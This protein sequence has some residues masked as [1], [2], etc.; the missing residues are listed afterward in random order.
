LRS[1]SESC[2]ALPETSF[3]QRKMRDLRGHAASRIRVANPYVSYCDV[4]DDTARSLI[5]GPDHQG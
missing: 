4:Y 1:P 5:D 2:H 3:G